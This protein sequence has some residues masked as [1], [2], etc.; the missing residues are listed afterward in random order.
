MK[1]TR[2]TDRLLTPAD[3]RA[4][5]YF[6]RNLHECQFAYINDHVAV[7][8]LTEETSPDRL[9]EMTQDQ[10]GQA[11]GC[12]PDFQPITLPDKRLIVLMAGNVL[13]LGDVV[14]RGGFQDALN[15]RSIGLRS[16]EIAPVLAIITGEDLTPEYESQD[17]DPD[18]PARDYLAEIL[19]A[20]EQAADE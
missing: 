5:S 11:L 6:R 2:T 10:I 16:C 14:G 1:I 9:L 19:D 17:V 8:L 4:I 15:A 18:A 12:Q 20:E 7:M 13:A 3:I